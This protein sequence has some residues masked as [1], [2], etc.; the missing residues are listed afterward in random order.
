MWWWQGEHG[1][2]FYVLDD[3]EFSVA[4]GEDLSIAPEILRYTPAPAG[5]ANPCFGELALLYSKPRAANVVALTDGVLW[6][7]DRKS[8]RAVLMKS[9]QT[10]LLRTL[11]AVQVRRFS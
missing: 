6:A 7:I 8:F 5:G 10:K 4:I 2:W 3:G 11:R 9:D 1:D